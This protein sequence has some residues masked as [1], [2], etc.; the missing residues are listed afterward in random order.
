MGLV[1]YDKL[2]NKPLVSLRVE[3]SAGQW[4]SLCITG[5]MLIGML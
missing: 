3:V 5:E 1:G 2:N 4:C